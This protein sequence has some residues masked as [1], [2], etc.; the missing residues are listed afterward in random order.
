MTAAPEIAADAHAIEQLLDA[1]L[2]DPGR[3]LSNVMAEGRPTTLLD[4]CAGVGT[5]SEAALK[6]SFVPTAID[7]HPIAVL[8]TR[9]L[10]VFPPAYA[11]PDSR[12]TGSAEDRSWRGL[13]EELRYWS[14]V[15]L[16]ATRIDLDELWLETI[17]AVVCAWIARCPNPGCGDER[18]LGAALESGV[19]PDASARTPFARGHATCPCCHCQFRVD[20]RQM[21]RLSTAKLQWLW[22][23]F[24]DGTSPA[25][26]VAS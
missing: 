2:S 7:L 6:L 19:A 15:V 18:P 22:L 4:L 1:Q 3:L 11:K 13:A 24:R 12:V 16:T 10:L 23:T 20:L 26:R 21:E 5:V 17:A 25:C 14:E 8:A 9:C